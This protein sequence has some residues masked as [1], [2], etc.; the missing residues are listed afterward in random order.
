[1]KILIIHS[2]LTG[3]VG[4]IMHAYVL[5]KNLSK[6]HGIEID[7]AGFPEDIAS[8]WQFIT[9]NFIRK[10]IPE[11][12]E[13]PEI[14]TENRINLFKNYDLI[15][16]MPGPFLSNMDHRKRYALLDLKIAKA[17]NKPFIFGGHSIG[18]IDNSDI[19]ILQ[20][21]DMIIARETI[22]HHY[23]NSINVNNHLSADYSFLYPIPFF[24]FQGLRYFKRYKLKYKVLFLRHDNLDY[25][26]IKAVDGMI[27][28][29][30]MNIINGSKHIIVLGSSDQYR[31][32]KKIK[33]LSKSIGIPHVICQ[34]P[35]ELIALISFSSGVV[36]D[37]YHPC[38]IA[39]RLGKNLKIIES[40]NNFKMD[41]LKELIQEK[42]NKEITNL[43]KAGVNLI[44]QFINNMQ[45]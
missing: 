28:Y 23:L 30:N 31:D 12:P 18:P 42:T 24:K 41:G 40:M 16:S 17:L 29:T 35:D 1:M 22:T 25:S 11:K 9:Q 4:D 8:N 26:K 5:V 34:N 7:I 21:A 45:T 44:H 37:R 6:I 2:W 38:I 13:D 15:I 33:A 3:N 43:A 14:N 10:C 19:K 36:S 32:Q 27:Q 39:H 20:Y